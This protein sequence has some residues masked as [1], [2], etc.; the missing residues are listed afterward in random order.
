MRLDLG[1]AASRKERKD[2]LRDSELQLQLALQGI[3]I[4]RM[5]RL[6]LAEAVRDGRLVRLLDEFSADEPVAIHA[7]YPHRRHLAAKVPAFVNFLIE[8]FTP[9]PWEI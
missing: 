3:G 7:I 5:T 2:G 8:K 9:P 6:T 1:D 4:A